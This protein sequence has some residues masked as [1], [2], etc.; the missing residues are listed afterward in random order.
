MN[1][2]NFRKGLRGRIKPIQVSSFGRNLPGEAKRGGWMMLEEG[3]SPKKGL[4]ATQVAAASRSLTS[5]GAGI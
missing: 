2:N 5:R 4:A 1:L 3:G